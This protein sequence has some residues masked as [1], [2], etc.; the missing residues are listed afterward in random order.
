M[1]SL[2]VDFFLGANSEH[3]FFS[4]FGQLQDPYSQ[5]KTYII[6]AGPGTGKSTMMK[7]IAE[8]YNGKDSLIERRYTAP[9]TRIPWTAWY[10]KTISFRLSTGH[11]RT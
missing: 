10:A 9:Q 4:H 6:K 3:G 7:R 11:R 1:N 2:I 5:E 8:E